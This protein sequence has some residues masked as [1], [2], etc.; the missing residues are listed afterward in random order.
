MY[1]FKLIHIPAKN[2]KGTNGLSRRRIADDDIDPE[3]SDEDD[4]EDDD[5]DGTEDQESDIDKNIK[6]WASEASYLIQRSG[7]DFT[8]LETFN[9]SAG[10]Q[11]QVFTTRL[12]YDFSIKIFNFFRLFN[13]QL[14]LQNHFKNTSLNKQKTSLFKTTSFGNDMQ[15][16]LDL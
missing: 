13:F 12:S 4:E 14:F 16:T 1:T 8:H 15:P 2:F 10:C 9:Y 3:E 11:A 7:Q 6:D 5:E